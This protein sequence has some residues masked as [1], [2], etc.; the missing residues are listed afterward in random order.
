MICAFVVVRNPPT[1][2][3]YEHFCTSIYFNPNPE[4][5][6]TRFLFHVPRN[7]FWTWARQVQRLL[8]EWLVMTWRSRLGGGPKPVLGW[9]AVQT[10]D[11]YLHFQSEGWDPPT[12][13]HVTLTGWQEHVVTISRYHLSVLS[14]LIT[15]ILF[16]NIVLLQSQVLP[17]QKWS[18]TGTNI[19]YMSKR[20]PVIL[21][22]LW[23]IE[24]LNTTPIGMC[25]APLSGC[26]WTCKWR[27]SLTFESLDWPFGIWS[28]LKE[29]RFCC[30]LHPAAL[31]EIPH[32]VNFHFLNNDIIDVLF[33]LTTAIT[34]Y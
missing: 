20:P 5:Y 10:Q 28:I 22:C 17:L 4:L 25:L 27:H 31:S 26:K 12:W 1:P 3:M 21:S 19:S 7:N 29:V 14:S 2:N 9:S 33:T 23:N 8:G 13:E 15:Q 11:S 6:E 16:W 32:C 18:Q 30:S 34:V 24:S